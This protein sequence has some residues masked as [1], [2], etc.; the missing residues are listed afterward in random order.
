M[1]PPWFCAINW[2]EQILAVINAPTKFV[3]IKFL[4]SLVSVSRKLARCNIPA[5]GTTISIFPNFSIAQSIIDSVWSSLVTSKA[6]GKTGPCNSFFASNNL[7]SL[8]SV[9][10]TEAPFWQ[11]AE[12]TAKPIPPAPPVIKATLS[13]SKLLCILFW[14]CYI[15][16]PFYTWLNIKF[17]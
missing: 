5:F 16:F 13:L 1:R 10:T 2:R 17:V 12:A 4:K 9:K 7:F 14:L 11:Y 15:R 8:K 6:Q 3:S